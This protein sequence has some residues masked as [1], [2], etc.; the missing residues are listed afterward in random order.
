MNRQIVIRHGA[1]LLTLLAAA[2]IAY[3]P[4]FTAWFFLDDFRIFLENAAL[5]DAF[6]PAAVWRFSQARFVVSW[7]LALNYTLHGEQVFGYHLFNFLIHVGAGMSLW[8]LARA[9]IRS[10][11]L[12]DSPDW[13]RWVP[14]LALAI[15]LLHPL[16]TQAVTYI[17]Q[18]YTSLMAMFYLASL[19]AFAWGRLRG[20][21]PLLGAALGLAALAM[22][23]KQTAATLPLAWL[24]IELTFLR[25][26]SA[27][28]RG[29]TLG[30]AAALALLAAWLVTL[31][32]LDVVGLTRETDRISRPDYLATQMEALW[33]Y[34]GHFVLIGE[35]RLE[36]DLALANGFSSPATWLMASG[37]LAVLA[38]GALLWQRQPLVSFGVLFYY[39]AHAIES[40][41]LPIIDVA[42][43]HRTYLPNAGLSMIA[44][45]ALLALATKIPVRRAAAFITIPALV[46]LT[47]ITWQ[48]NQLWTDPIEFLTH[49]ARLNPGSQRA[50]TSLGK[51]LMR[52]QRFQEALDAMETALNIAK[53]EQDGQFRP[54][55]L[56][57][58]LFAYHYTGRNEQALEFARQLDT[59]AFNPK[60]KAFFL[61][62]RGRARLA[63]GR[64][65][66]ARNDLTKAA[67]INP[68]I[69]VVT[70]L[71]AAELGVGNRHRAGQL[72]QQVLDTDPGNQVARE[73]LE[74]ARHAP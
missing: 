74:R 34:L 16:Q 23:S 71:A 17:V 73:I 64:F 56:L 51:E 26:L 32:S 19:A 62:A 50:W 41:F 43:E 39:L 44:A 6:D 5:H 12:A 54:P 28:A 66:S 4:S 10:P 45:V 27:R 55:T 13:S 21:A 69:A 52:E 36:Y 72:A 70:Y 49:D 65:S 25:R 61:E 47:A 67:R 57:N 42:F 60:E 29:V 2:T 9:L 37:H 63:L 40:S 33:R 38:A 15:F 48:R 1:L 7:T 3:L 24:L 30:T 68:S 18:R 8:L 31:P 20:S 22:L 11:A 14:W 53:I 46:L 35:Q 59:R 58:M